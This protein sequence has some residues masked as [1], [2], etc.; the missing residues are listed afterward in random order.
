MDDNDTIPIPF[1]TTTKQKLRLYH[2][3]SWMAEQECFDAEFVVAVVEHAGQYEGTFDLLCE[4]KFCFDQ[5]VW[6]EYGD[7]MRALKEAVGVE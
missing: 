2:I 5:Q 7:T 4:L 3:A 6:D 1:T